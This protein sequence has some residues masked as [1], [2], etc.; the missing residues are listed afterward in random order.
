[1]LKKRVITA[2]IA[3]PLLFAAVIINKYIFFCALCL[4]SIIGLYEYYSAA[5]KTGVKPMIGLGVVSG[6]VLLLLTLFGGNINYMTLFIAIIMLIVLSVPIF[7]NRYNF[8]SSAV[9]IIGVLYLPFLFRYLYLIRAIQ[10]TGV[11][12]IWFVFIVA[13]MSDT[14]AYFTG[15]AFGRNKLCPAISP[16]KTVEGSI[17]GIIGSTVGCIIYGLLLAK[18]NIID[19]HVID[20]L[21][22]GISG[23][24]IS[25]IGDL[26]ASAIKRNAGIKDYGNIMPGHGGILDRFDSILFAAPL[27]YYYIA[28]IIR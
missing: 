1:M 10:N 28:Y 19:I 5:G 2:I 20:L 15:R 27:V 21:I 8:L 23:S 17:G 26:A 9:T 12:L 18:Y 25:Q 22:I 13:W 24:I 4:I 16:K 6:L 3:L 11:Y 7:N 14:F